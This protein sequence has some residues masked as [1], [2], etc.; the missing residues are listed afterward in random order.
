M[1]VV[2]A[3]GRLRQ[4]HCDCHAS[5]GYKSPYQNKE[6]IEQLCWNHVDSRL[7]IQMDYVTLQFSPSESRLSSHT[8]TLCTSRCQDN[9]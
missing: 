9:M 8:N 1:L 5:L 2:L 4:D 6:E 3:L 7:Q